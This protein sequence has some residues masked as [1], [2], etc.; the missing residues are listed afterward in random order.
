MKKISAKKRMM[1]V[2]N[3]DFNFLCYMVL[4]TLEKFSCSS[5]KK[6]F[7]DYRK[8]AF[9]SNI[10]FWKNKTDWNKIYYESQISI[11]TLEMI[12]QSL[13]NKGVINVKLN[14]KRKTVDIWIADRTLSKLF[15][16][17]AM[18]T[19]ELEELEVIRKINNRLR[20][21]TLSTFLDKQFS[22]HGVKVWEV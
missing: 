9:I 21:S 10:V 22:L 20:T 6:S 18:F 17:E 4:L 8:I 14:D 1:F 16:N 7:V 5:E 19:H 15:V 11:K 12:I 13:E 3:N 2:Q